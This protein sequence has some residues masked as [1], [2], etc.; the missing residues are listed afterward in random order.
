VK[1]K[2][3]LGDV[4]SGEFF[5]GVYVLFLIMGRQIQRGWDFLRKE[6]AFVSTNDSG[7]HSHRG[8]EPGVAALGG[9]RD[10]S[11]SPCGR[12]WNNKKK[13]GKTNDI[14]TR[15]KKGEGPVLGGGG[16]RHQKK[17]SSTPTTEEGGSG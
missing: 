14:S 13:K 17:E 7:K 3:H 6:G 1:K 4:I 15:N 2:S 12:G 10:P 11:Q 9:D 8:G 5:Q 16:L